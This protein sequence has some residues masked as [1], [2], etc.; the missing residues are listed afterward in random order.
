MHERVGRP[1]KVFATAQGADAH[2]SRHLAMAVRGG[3][4]DDDTMIRLHAMR[5]GS[6]GC[7]RLLAVRGV[8]HCHAVGWGGASI[9]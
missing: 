3:R 8:S 5:T 9:Q 6:T 1:R 2:A 7:L 4:P